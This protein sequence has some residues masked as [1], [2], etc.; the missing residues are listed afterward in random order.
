M[1]LPRKFK[2]IEIAARIRW[3]VSRPFRKLNS[4]ENK[5]WVKVCGED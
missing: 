3:K 2:Q 5:E 4:Y 1:F